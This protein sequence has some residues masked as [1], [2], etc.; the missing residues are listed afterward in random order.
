MKIRGFIGIAVKC[1]GI[2]ISNAT[3]SSLLA[4]LR[5][6]LSGS[7]MAYEIQALIAKSGAIGSCC[8]ENILVVSLRHDMEMLPICNEVQE[9]FDI[10][11]L[12][13]TDKGHDLIPASL[14]KLCKEL[15]ATSKV[16]YIEAEF[17]GG[18]G[19]QAF[20][21]YEC[22]KLIEGPVTEPSRL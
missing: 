15:S 2:G 4:R 13:L 20:A 7:I 18:D 5:V 9:I 11:F 3:I 16:A 6:R 10:P 19:T 17:F 22:G 1:A 12:P 14:D 8:P 21:L